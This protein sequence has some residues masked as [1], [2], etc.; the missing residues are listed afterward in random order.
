[1][2]QTVNQG[3][4]VFTIIPSENASYIAKL[5]TPAKNSG[6]IKVG[7]RVNIKL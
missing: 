2:N 5:K 6:K 3:D 4:L 1:M 7:Q